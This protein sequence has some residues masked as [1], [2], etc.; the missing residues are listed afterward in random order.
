MF[1]SDWAAW[2]GP[3]ATPP[4]ET[5][6]SDTKPPVP[7]AA[8]RAFARA[9]AHPAPLPAVRTV[10]PPT[11]DERPVARDASVAIVITAFKQPGYL[12][13]A[14][15]SAVVQTRAANEIIVVCGDEPSARVAREFASNHKTIRVLTG[16]DRG[17]ADARNAGFSAARSHFVLPLDGDDTIEPDFL[18]QTLAVAPD[19]PVAM[20][21]TNMKN[22]GSGTGVWDLSPYDAGKLLNQNLV[23]CCTLITKHLWRL[24]G[25]YDVSLLGCEDWAFWIA[26]SRHAPV[27]RHVP[28][29]LLSYRVHDQNGTATTSAELH[30]FIPSTVRLRH[31]DAYANE[32]VARDLDAVA[33]MS[34]D[35][36]RRLEQR[37]EWF[38]GDPGAHLFRGIYR[39]HHGDTRGA[40][41]DFKLAALTEPLAARRLR[42]ITPPAAPPPGAAHTF[43]QAMAIIGKGCLPKRFAVPTERDADYTLPK[44]IHLFWVGSEIPEKYVRNV[45]SY[46]DQNPTYEIILWVDR[47]RAPID[48]VRIEMV[49]PE[50]LILR[51]LYEQEPNFGAK[52][53]IASY[54]ILYQHGGIYCDIDSTALKPFDGLFSRA[55]VAATFDPRFANI[56]HGIFGAPKGSLFLAYVLQ[57][58]KEHYP[59]MLG[60]P[61]GDI[62]K[63]S[64]PTFF[65]TAFVSYGDP[66]IRILEQKLVLNP[67]EYTVHQNDANWAK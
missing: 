30:T 20:V 58:L 36:L 35:A 28:E 48:R 53:D 37:I 67:G 56:C 19:S 49:R 3:K 32:Q 45:E 6:K 42:E 31:A 34:A 55:F 8:D 47:E 66:N 24:A 25:G 64:G 62:P 10:T 51:E 63:R 54:D 50:G 4:Q 21:T 61:I 23:T 22:I 27:V 12:A 13:E 38:P 7:T 59:T 43:A 57:C 65:T 2:Q 41:A 5:Q 46:R 26:C 60:C 9:H 52:V 15:T 16:Y 18:A 17:A 1:G 44:K 14:I 11:P 39:Q 29:R 33:N 40:I